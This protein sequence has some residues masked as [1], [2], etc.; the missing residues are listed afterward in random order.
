MFEAPLRLAL[1]LGALGVLLEALALLLGSRQLRRLLYG[2]MFVLTIF[3]AVL[4]LATDPRLGTGL[5]A[6]VAAY[7]AVNAMRVVAGRIK[8]SRLRQATRRSSLMLLGYQTVT[9]VLWRLDV[10]TGY[11]AR[12]TLYG[13]LAVSAAAGLVMAATTRRS[14]KK[15]SL[16]D[17]DKYTSDTELPTVSICIPARNETADLPACLESVLSSDYPKLEVLVLDDCSQDKTSEIIKGF[18]HDGVR[19]IAGEEPKAGWLAKNQAYD[20]LAESASGELLLFM[21]V[22]VRLDK[23]S[24]SKLVGSMSAREKQM[25][26]LLPRGMQQYK[27]AGLVQP[28]RYWWELALPR[29]LFNR[30]PVLSSLWMIQRQSLK[31]LGGFKAVRGSVLPE[32]FFARE[33]TKK[34][35]Y[36]FMRASLELPISSAKRL[37]EQWETAVRT[38]Y[39]ELRHRPENVLLLAAAELWFLILPLGVFLTGFF[40]PMGGLWTLAGLNVLVLLYVQYLVVRIWGLRDAGLP[41]A[42]LPAAVLTELAV[43]HISMWKYEFS[44]VIWK[45]RNICI[46]V[47]KVTKHLPGLPSKIRAMPGFY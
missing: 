4:L 30:P 11:G 19:F 17:S 33:L 24:V 39:P 12:Q 15:T 34:D 6:I 38:H 46:P 37:P 18:A 21:G 40:I 14:L 25:I 28:L 47:M 42:V 27:D 5:V 23:S 10:L 7:R 9:L 3:A 29:R 2:S 44:E 43:L 22:D 32:G 31:D 26:S 16:R 36:S 35:G 41:L 45:D 1:S 20:T 8:E 13:L